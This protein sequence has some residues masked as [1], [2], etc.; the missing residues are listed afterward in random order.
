MS[1]HAIFAASWPLLFSGIFAPVQTGGVAVIVT[2][3]VT[4]PK[5]L[6]FTHKLDLLTSWLWP[7]GGFGVDGRLLFVTFGTFVIVHPI[8]HVNSKKKALKKCKKKGTRSFRACYLWLRLSPHTMGQQRSGES[9]CPKQTQWKTAW[10]RFQAGNKTKRTR[11]PFS[12]NFR[13]PG[14]SSGA[15]IFR[16][17]FGNFPGVKGRASESQKQHKDMPK[18]ALRIFNSCHCIHTKQ[19]EGVF[20]FSGW[21]QK[22]AGGGGTL[23]DKIIWLMPIPFTSHNK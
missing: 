13:R 14:R 12:R 8:P 5:L 4:A 23:S 19:S 7:M 9:V 16:A 18:E 10:Q 17:Q 11:V 20:G 2:L 15:P 22:T 21:S 3:T 1:A 6:T